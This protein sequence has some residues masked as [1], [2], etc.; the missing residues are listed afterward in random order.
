MI[1]VLSE[2]RDEKNG[3]IFVDKCWITIY[4]QFKILFLLEWRINPMIYCCEE[5]VEIAIDTIVD[6]FETFP[7]LNKI[8]DEKLSTT[9]EYCQK[10]AVYMVANE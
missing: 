4:P 10:H 6:D 9:C 7:I 1:L 8:D 5:H 2:T 3:K